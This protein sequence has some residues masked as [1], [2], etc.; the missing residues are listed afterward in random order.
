MSGTG[1]LSELSQAKD[2][3]G[4]S[5][6]TCVRCGWTMGE[7]SLNCQ[8]DDTPHRFPSQGGVSD[9]GV[10]EGAAAPLDA[11]RK[12]MN[13]LQLKPLGISHSEAIGIV[14]RWQDADGH[15]EYGRDLAEY[16]GDDGDETAW[17]FAELIVT[18]LNAL[19]E[20][21]D[22]STTET[23]KTSNQELAAMRHDAEIELGREDGDCL[24]SQLAYHEG[25]LALVARVEA[26]LAERDALAQECETRELEAHG[27]CGIREQLEAAEG[28]VAV[29]EAALRALVESLDDEAGLTMSPRLA[30]AWSN[31]RQALYEAGA[32]LAGG[33]AAPPGPW[34]MPTGGV[35]FRAG[36]DAAAEEKP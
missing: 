18:V 5:E 11:I 12:L 30:D 29:L 32:V 27:P 13:E 10:V 22:A 23:A 21:L 16:I 15:L 7:P 4:Y 17:K 2:S 33:D 19:P 36:G 14:E 25:V 26:L 8:N 3:Q 9:R 1:D 20:L 28:R 6:E 24:L 35:P 34:V 31:G